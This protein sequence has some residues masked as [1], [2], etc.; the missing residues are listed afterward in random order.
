LSHH[1]RSDY[2][3]IPDVRALMSL[4]DHADALSRRLNRM[5]DDL[6]DYRQRLI[7]DDFGGDWDEDTDPISPR[8]REIEDLE[9]IVCARCSQIVAAFEALS[10]PDKHLV[11]SYD[12]A[13]DEDAREA[14]ADARVRWMEDGCPN[15]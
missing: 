15:N 6:F 11:E 10:A 8:R 13:L 12:D 3:G 7:D 14:R 5:K 4:R 1:E 2:G 9:M